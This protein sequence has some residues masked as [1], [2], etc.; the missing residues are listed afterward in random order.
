MY[1]TA[2]CSDLP[3]TSPLKLQ[4]D[5]DLRQN[6]LHQKERLQTRVYALFVEMQHLE[7]RRCSRD[8][9][10]THLPCMTRPGAQITVQELGLTSITDS[11][12]WALPP[13]F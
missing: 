6:P 12:V 2:D 8:H 11:V 1:S 3:T 5:V 4:F 9:T 7:E 10:L 13:S